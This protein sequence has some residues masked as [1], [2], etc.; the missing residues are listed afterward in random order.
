M[1]C[2]RITEDA[3]M[4]PVS[5]DPGL[6]D[7]AAMLEP[8]GGMPG[9]TDE[10]RATRTIAA[11]LAFAAEGHTIAAGAFR[12][13]VGRL[14]AYLKS[15]QT[16]SGQEQRLIQI[17]IDAASGAPVPDGPWLALAFNAGAGWWAFGQ[18]LK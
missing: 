15:L 4:P 11:V 18:A 10:S 14:L 3:A 12:R 9:D 6:I 5:G 17:A 7:L 13:H 16:A 2:R 8:D 1:F